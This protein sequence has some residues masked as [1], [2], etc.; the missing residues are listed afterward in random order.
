MWRLDLIL[1]GKARSLFTGEILPVKMSGY[2]GPEDLEGAREIIEA[3]YPLFRPILF[4]VPKES[5]HEII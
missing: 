5:N 1:T 3:T 4:L 2:T